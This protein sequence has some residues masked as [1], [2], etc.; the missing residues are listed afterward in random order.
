MRLRRGLVRAAD[1]AVPV[2]GRGATFDI[3]GL[4]AIVF[5]DG[6]VDLSHV[7]A[8]QHRA[9]NERY[10]QYDHCDCARHFERLC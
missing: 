9:R 8:D 7:A 2:Y 10:G 5:R 6:R 1:R 3:Y 4:A